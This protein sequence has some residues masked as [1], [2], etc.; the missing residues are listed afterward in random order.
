MLVPVVKKTEYQLNY[1]IGD[2]LCLLDTRGTMRSDIRCPE[3][4]LGVDIKK[5]LSVE[6]ELMI[7]LLSYE[8]EE[9]VVAAKISANDTAD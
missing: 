4:K 8:G 2:L 3:G 7:T 6:T 1:M 5:D 9:M